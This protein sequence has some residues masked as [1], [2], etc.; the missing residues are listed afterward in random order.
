MKSWS[1]AA[2]PVKSKITNCLLLQHLT[3]MPNI[4]HRFQWKSCPHLQ[5]DDHPLSF[6]GKREF[7][8]GQER[9]V[10][11]GFMNQPDRL[12]QLCSHTV[13]NFAPFPVIGRGQVPAGQQ[14]RHKSWIE[15]TSCWEMLSNRSRTHIFGITNAK[16]YTFL[17]ALM[18]SEPHFGGKTKTASA[19]VFPRPRFCQR[20]DDTDHLLCFYPGE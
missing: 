10:G 19:F 6:G 16:G 20:G 9:E 18:I 15:F 14:P 4:P 1:P 13:R 8:L 17:P 12:G 7:R 3:V 5:S 11:A 2:V